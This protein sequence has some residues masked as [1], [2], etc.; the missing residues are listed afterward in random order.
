[1]DRGKFYDT[2][3]PMFGGKMKQSQVDGC[4][5][6][7]SACNGLPITWTAYLL[8]TA[9]HETASTMLPVRETL[10]STDASAV[11]RLESSWK[12]GKLKWVKTPYWRFDSS[13]KTWLGRGYVQLTHKDNYAKASKLT[14]VDLLADPN[15]AMQPEAAAKI[16]VEG[17]ISGMFTGKKLADYLP[18]DYTGARRI[19]NGTDKAS[20]IAGYAKRFEEGLAAARWGEA[21]PRPKNVAD[22]LTK[23]A[24]GG[25]F[26]AIAAF[27]SR[28]FGGV[29]K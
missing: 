9:L 1:M 5:R 12:A 29:K 19:I 4:E 26:N 16:L 15:R 22:Y 7:L 28:L 14:G 20:L 24:T 13:G 3:R 2:I 11:S 27:L 25:F 17:S 10:A 8:A 21:V 18:G 23:P 6:I